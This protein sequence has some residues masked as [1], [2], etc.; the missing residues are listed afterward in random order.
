[1]EIE[2]WSP[3]LT[4]IKPGAECFSLSLT[5]NIRYPQEFQKIAALKI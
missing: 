4:E 5:L 1:M 3:Y 2:C